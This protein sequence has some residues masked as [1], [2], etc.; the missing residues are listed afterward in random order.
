MK[1][2]TIGKIIPWILV[3]CLALVLAAL[4]ALAR[5]GAEEA[6]KL[7]VLSAE[8]RPGTLEITLAG[9]GTLK[10]QDAKEIELYDGVE[11][12]ELL[13]KN[14]DYVRKG[15]SLACVDKTSAM[16]AIL[17]VYEGLEAL[18][19]QIRDLELESRYG[20]VRAGAP[21]RVKAVYARYGDNVRD[22]MLE[23]GALAVISLDGRMA[24]KFDAARP[25]RAGES[26]TVTLTDGSRYPGIAETY[27]EGR[28]VVCI[29]DDGPGLRD[30]ALVTA[31]DGTVLGSGELYVHCAWNAVASSGTVSY[32]D[33]QEGEKVGSGT[34]VVR[35]EN[36]DLPSGYET[37]LKQHEEY[38]R[39]L[40]SLFPIWTD[41]VI[42]APCDG[43]VSKLDKGIVKTAFAGQGGKLVLLADEVGHSYC[44]TFYRI[45]RLDEKGG[46]I[47]DISAEWPAPGMLDDS[48]LLGLSGAA[49]ASPAEKDV[50]V[51]G[52]KPGDVFYVLTVDG[53][54][55]DAVKLEYGG[56]GGFDLGGLS[57]GG[58]QEAEAVYELESD[59]LCLV[60][61]NETMTVRIM[62]DEQDILQYRPG[63]EAEILVDALP[64]QRYTGRVTWLGGVGENSGGSS[65]FPVEL[66]LTRSPDM[67]DGMNASVIVYKE[68]VEGLLIPVAAVE[69]SGSRT[70]VHTGY[71]AKS[72]QPS[73]PTEIV[74]GASD[75]EQ[76]VVLSGLAEGQTVWYQYYGG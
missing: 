37:L 46:A 41:G 36:M 2:K 51:M 70:F 74:T 42:T 6:S 35:L 62:V 54:A 20:L 7:R 19:K 4:P 76:A 61:P 63:M 16:T 58:T 29:T 52:G 32:S 34:V 73:D 9:G 11:V 25:L 65:K 3:A 21:G 50:P 44:Y 38:S 66:T 15:E 68:R 60:T 27:L 49:L 24:V 64:G 53:I 59:I 45:T 23:Y 17:N 47:G 18:E 8:V 31:A 13:V 22:V 56:F 57:F 10:A 43:Y 40:A 48:T 28:A 14:G 75:G 30:T 67:L 69:G 55:G 5:S 12:T 1:R 33:L 71:D 72:G 26:V 39:R